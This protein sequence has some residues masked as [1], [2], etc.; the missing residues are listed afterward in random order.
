M[1]T[2]SN[3]QDDPRSYEGSNT[4]NNNQ[5]NS[6][7]RKEMMP[8]SIVLSHFAKYT[9]EDGE[10]RAQN[11]YYS[12]SYATDPTISGTTSVKNQMKSCLKNPYNN[13]AH[14]TQLKQQP[15]SFTHSHKAGS[16][17]TWRYNQNDTRK[18][19]AY[20]IIV[21]EQPF[22]FVEKKDLHILCLLLAH[23]SKFH[24]ELPLQGI[25]MIYIWKKR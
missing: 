3:S 20:M 23:L 1:N 5:Q 13:E 7:K 16:I 17:V 10:K 19:C 22:S 21:D 11:N 12:L 25:A 8:R 15:H 2:R 24:V 14:A 9:I 4:S 18:V 6:K